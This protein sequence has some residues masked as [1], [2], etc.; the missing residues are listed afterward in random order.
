MTPSSDVID[1]LADMDLIVSDLML[2]YG[3]AGDLE[4]M[5]ELLK[6][7]HSIGELL[8]RPKIVEESTK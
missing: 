2:I 7:S 5:K 1:R 4:A 6:I 8:H 3:K